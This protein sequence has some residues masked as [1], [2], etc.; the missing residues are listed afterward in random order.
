MPFFGPFKF[1]REDI[2]NNYSVQVPLPRTHETRAKQIRE[3]LEIARKN[4]KIFP[5]ES[6]EDLAKFTSDYGS[7]IEKGNLAIV[8]DDSSNPDKIYIRSG[9][10]GSEYWHELNLGEGGIGGDFLNN[11]HI[12]NIA[13]M[14]INKLWVDTSES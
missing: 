10:P 1:K 14:D 3:T 12:S 7:L 9:T 4:M 6:A 13:P 2:R 5:I 11:I 8:Y